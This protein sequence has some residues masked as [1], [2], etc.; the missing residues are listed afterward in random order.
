MENDQLFTP[1]PYL[2]EKHSRKRGMP[3]LRTSPKEQELNTADL[4]QAVIK[5]IKARGGYAVRINCFGIYDEKTGRWRKSTT[6]RGTADI[7]AC[8]DGKHVSIEI[9]YGDD[10]LSNHQR[11]VQEDVLKSGGIYLIVSEFA[12]FHNWY[13]NRSAR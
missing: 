7:H 6:E 2:Q 11:T 9:K 4:T 3:R 8:I 12:E 10:R 1:L 13:K 5:Y